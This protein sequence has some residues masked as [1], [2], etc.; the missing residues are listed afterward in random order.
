MYVRSLWPCYIRGIM[1]VLFALTRQILLAA[2]FF[3]SAHNF[4]KK[5]LAVFAELLKNKKKVQ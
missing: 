5:A 4:G 3:C 2:W 1:F